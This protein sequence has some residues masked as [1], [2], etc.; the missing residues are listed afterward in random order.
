MNSP[1]GS[2]DNNSGNDITEDSDY[3]SSLG[4]Q[5]NNADNLASVMQY[6]GNNN[7]SNESQNANYS[8]PNSNLMSRTSY[9][10]TNFG[11]ANERYGRMAEYIKTKNVSEVYQ[12]I[13]ELTTAYNLQRGNDGSPA[14]TN[15][16]NNPYT[17]NRNIAASPQQVFTMNSQQQQQ[18]DVSDPTNTN[19]VA[20][21]NSGRSTPQSAQQ[22]AQTR[23]TLKR[24]RKAPTTNNSDAVEPP[25][26]QKVK[27]EENGS[28][29]GIP[30]SRRDSI[31][32][33]INNGN[34]NPSQQQPP[35]NMSVQNTN[36]GPFVMN[37]NNS[38]NASAMTQQL[39][40]AT[41]GGAGGQPNATPQSHSEVFI[42]DLLEHNLKIIS[43]IRFNMAHGRINDNITLISKFR[44]NIIQV[45][46]CMSKMGGI[47][48][49]MPPIPVKLNTICIP[50]QQNGQGNNNRSTPNQQQ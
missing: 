7:Q 45:L 32:Q 46:T 50:Q 2:G 28:G 11:N 18:Q 36:S 13:H 10:V 8:T 26:K 44:E 47:M 34:N 21:N 37:A 20:N 38:N 12:K 1:L 40:N 49:R 14:Q 25:K 43:T 6:R 33:N 9:P 30:Q 22:Q 29:G 19:V 41:G 24:T 42:N 27:K 31:Q 16:V 17:N 4:M 35:Q 3:R 48:S 15:P 23:T 39:S 5:I